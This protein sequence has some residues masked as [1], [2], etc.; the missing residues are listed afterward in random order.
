LL[1]IDKQVQCVI[2]QDSISLT[3][4]TATGIAAA[5]AAGAAIPK[6]AFPSPECSS[7]TVIQPR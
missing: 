2:L 6:L 5:V 1:H 3:G 4:A 7:G